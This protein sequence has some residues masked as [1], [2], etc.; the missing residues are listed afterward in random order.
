MVIPVSARK[1]VLSNLHIQH[2]GKSKTLADARQLYNCPEMTN[3][4]GIMVANCRECTVALPSQPLEPQIPT[5]ATRPFE[6]IS[7]DL[8]YQ[9]GKN[10]LIGID[11]YSG[12]PMAAPIP[13]KANTRTITDILDNWLVEHG[14]PVSIRT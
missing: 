5:K 10:Y 14:I 7:I 8:R 3:A 12:W 6:R 11:R 13:K 4:I 9:K 1:K 2:T